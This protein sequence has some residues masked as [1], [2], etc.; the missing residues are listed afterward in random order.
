MAVLL[1]S[2]SHLPGEGLEI[3]PELLLLLPCCDTLLLDGISPPASNSLWAHP[4]Y[5]N[6]LEPYSEVQSQM[7][8]RMPDR[9]SRRVSEAN[10]RLSVRMPNRMPGRMQDGGCQ[11]EHQRC[12]G[13]HPKANR[14]SHLILCCTI[15]PGSLS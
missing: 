1:Y 2:F 7:S 3:L 10:A 12:Q 15:T 13:D 6:I 9:R 4:A 11:V 5:L 14:E 8:E